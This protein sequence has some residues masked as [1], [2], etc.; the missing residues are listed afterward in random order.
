MSA[1]RAR[2]TKVRR[3]E[4]RMIRIPVSLD[5]LRKIASIPEPVK[6]VPRRVALCVMLNC[7]PVSQFARQAVA[8]GNRPNFYRAGLLRQKYRHIWTI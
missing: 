3:N 8:L 4:W 2:I 5:N 1:R 6:L 7:A